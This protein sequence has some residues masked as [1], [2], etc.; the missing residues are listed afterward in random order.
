MLAGWG[1]E[2][3]RL[4]AQ[5]PLRVPSL[6]QRPRLATLPFARPRVAP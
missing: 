1:L 2:R 4:G 5:R 3:L 6:N